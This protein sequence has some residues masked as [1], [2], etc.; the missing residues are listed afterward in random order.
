MFTPFLCYR[1]LQALREKMLYGVLHMK[2][3]CLL[4][5]VLYTY[6]VLHGVKFTMRMSPQS[7]L[8]CQRVVHKV[9]FPKNMD[10]F[11]YHIF[12]GLHRTLFFSIYVEY[13]MRQDLSKSV[14]FLKS[15]NLLSPQ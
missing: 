7:K 8:Y 5:V 1:V 6:G 15:I 12:E 9:Q 11:K 10:F 4:S 3:N 14:E 13:S 2:K